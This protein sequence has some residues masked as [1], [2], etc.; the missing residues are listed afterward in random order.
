MVPLVTEPMVMEHW[1]WKKSIER[2]QL[3]DASD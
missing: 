1:T 2:W 3:V